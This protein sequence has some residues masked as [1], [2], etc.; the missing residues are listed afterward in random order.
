MNSNTNLYNKIAGI[1][2]LEVMKC[3]P[4]LYSVEDHISNEPPFPHSSSVLLNFD[5]NFFLLTAGHCVHNLDLNKV[6]IMLDHDFCTIGGTLKYFEPN[7]D[8]NYDPTNYDIA[9]FKLDAETIATFKEKYNFLEINKLDFNHISSEASRYMIF[10]YPGELT[11]ND[12]RTKTIVPAP[13][14]LRMSSV[15]FSFYLKENIDKSKTLVLSVDQKAV[16]TADNQFVSALSPLG[17][18]SGCGVWHISDLNTSN[19]KY[20]LVS[21]LTGENE[22]QTTLY[23]TKI[24]ILP[25]ILKKDFGLT[26]R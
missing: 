21:I 1:I 4:Q 26:I 25:L 23:S 5:E 2:S 14:K 7:D 22:T 20:H 11:E 12:F 24:D 17:G 16:G 10:G 13:L 6:G 18:I 3:T 15:P 19:P 9:I 8:D